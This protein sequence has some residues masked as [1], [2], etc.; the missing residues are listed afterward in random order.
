MLLFAVRLLV[1]FPVF[2]LRHSS[3]EVTFGYAQDS[4]H[5]QPL[6]LWE[7]GVSLAPLL[8]GNAVNDF[9]PRFWQMFGWPGLGCHTLLEIIEIFSCCF[10]T[11]CGS[12]PQGLDSHPVLQSLRHRTPT[13]SG[14]T[15]PKKEHELEPAENASV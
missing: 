4:P 7:R 1:D 6:S 15:Q 12:D 13:A 3:I 2:I 11:V 14:V 5:P 10:P 8:A 9:S